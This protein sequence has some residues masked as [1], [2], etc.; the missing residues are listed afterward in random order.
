MSEQLV[1]RDFAGTPEIS[2]GAN[3]LKR[4]ALAMSRDV[5][6]VEDDGQQMGAVEALRRLKEI[7]QGLETSRKAIKAPVLELGRKIDALASDFYRDCEKEEM[8]IQGLIN[9]YQREQMQEQSDR[10]KQLE[11]MTVKAGEL[12][13]QAALEKDVAKRE[14]LMKQAFDLEM[15]QEVTV[16]AGIEKPKGLVVRRK[17]NFQVIDAIVFI[18]AYPKFW[19]WNADNETLKLD[20]MAVLDELN[21][22]DGKGIFHRTRFPEELSASDD[23]RLVRPAGIRVFEETKAFVR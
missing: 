8:R 1:L 2:P 5:L 3:E 23:E 4:Q 17:I 10:E 16:V 15:T 20:R 18:Q 13:H 7:R 21:T 11:Q 12:R 9:H 19:K 22:E 6:K 14:E